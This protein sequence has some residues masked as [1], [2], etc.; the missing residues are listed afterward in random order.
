VQCEFADA[1]PIYDG[2]ARVGAISTKCIGRRRTKMRVRFLVV[3][4]KGGN[5]AARHQAW[6]TV[7]RTPISSQARP[8]APAR[9]P[10]KQ[11]EPAH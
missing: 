10:R 7:V 1:K 11:F 2:E 8:A 6:S 3:E 4:G 9:D 5:F